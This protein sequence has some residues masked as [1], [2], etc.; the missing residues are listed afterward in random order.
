MTTTTRATRGVPVPQ[1]VEYHRVLVGEKRRIGRGIL[2]IVLLLAGLFGS[3]AVLYEVGVWI[4]GL[5]RPD[6]DV[7]PGLTPVTQTLSL[8]SVALMIPWSM[9]IQRWLYGVRGASLHS[10]ISSFRFDL[11]GRALLILVPL[12]FIATAI[13]EYSR[14]FG[15]VH[16]SP[17]DII[18][19]LLASVLLVPLQATGEEYG[20]R[21]LVFRVAASWGR[22]RVTSLLLGIG[23]STA[24]FSAIHVASDPWWNV[25]YVA[26][27]TVT[28]YATWRTG[29]IEIAAIIH[30]A[31]NLSTFIFWIALNADLAE[32]F[33]RSPGGVTPGLMIPVLVILIGVTVVVWFRTRRTGPALTPSEPSATGSDDRTPVGALT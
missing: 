31:V 5:I 20:F 14:P 12:F 4:D 11:F 7:G 10:V 27:S 18:G 16:W 23:V 24:V 26:V 2:A 3:G 8:L 17:T 33:D 6:G 29:G 1:G 30:S 19:V 32:R 25:F 21:G 9:L 13:H 22:G 28:A 15:T